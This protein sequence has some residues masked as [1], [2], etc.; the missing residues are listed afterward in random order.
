MH[1]N[2]LS[3]LVHT[4]ITKMASLM[5]RK[6]LNVQAAKKAAKAAKVHTFCYSSVRSVHT[7]A[8]M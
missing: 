4:H 5:S 6:A 7:V 1:I 3:Q 2:Q 8:R